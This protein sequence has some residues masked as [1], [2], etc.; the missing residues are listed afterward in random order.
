MKFPSP[1]RAFFEADKH[2]AGPAPISAFAIDAV[3]KDEGK[4][5]VGQTAIAAWW[6][7]SKAQYRHTA[8]PRQITESDGRI[9]V[10]AEVSGDFPGSPAMLN[11][12]FTLKED[13]IATLEIGA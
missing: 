5:H 1:I 6:R 12:T 13:A 3:V 9:T 11:F 4:M 10:L 8:D 7:A 2:V